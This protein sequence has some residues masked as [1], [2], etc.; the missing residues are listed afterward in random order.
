MTLYFR[1]FFVTTAT[2]L[3]N[4]LPTATLQNDSLYFRLFQKVQN[5]DKLISFGFLAYPWLRPYSKH[6]LQARSKACIFV[7]YSLS[8][9][10]CHLINPLTNKIYTSRHVQFI[11]TEF[12]YAPLTKTTTP[13]PLTIDA[14]LRLD[15]LLVSYQP[16]QNLSP[17]TSSNTPYPHS[18]DSHP[19]QHTINHKLSSRKFY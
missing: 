13:P 7:S 5:Y 3:I 10:A 11:E 14:W 12:P 19:S 8:Q 15:I 2:Y 18:S 4:C 6:K 17:T 9:S 1:A 16:P